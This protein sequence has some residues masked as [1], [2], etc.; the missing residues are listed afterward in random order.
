MR[1]PHFAPAAVPEVVF[2]R[3]NRHYQPA[4]SLASPL[5]QSASLDLGVGATRGS[6][7]LIDMNTAF[8]RFVRRALREALRVDEGRFPDRPPGAWLDEAGVVP[9]KPDLCLLEDRQVVCVGD[10]KYK[11]LPAGAYRNTDLYQLLAYTVALDL[12]SGTLI[13]AADEGVSEAE[14]V[15]VRSGKRLRVV[16][17]DLSARPAMVLRQIAAVARRMKPFVDAERHVGEVAFSPTQPARV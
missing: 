2:T 16:S 14:H 9:L 6:A 11:R 5:L 1:R 17:L 13:Y 7:L 10:A 15:V 4:L 8:E 3:L 12:P